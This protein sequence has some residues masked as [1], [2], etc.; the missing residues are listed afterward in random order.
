VQD[1]G[2]SLTFNAPPRR[3]VTYYHLALEMMIALGL[4]S[5]VVGR[6][7]FSESPRLPQQEAAFRSIP[8]IVPGPYPPAREQ[9]LAKA[10]DFVFVADPV[11]ELDRDRGYADRA[12]LEAGGATVYVTAA[13]CNDDRPATV[14]DVYTDLTNL[15]RIFG[16][17]GR[18]EALIKQIQTRIEATSAKVSGRTPKR[19]MVYSAGTGPL[20]VLTGRYF[21]LPKFAGGRNVFA[22]EP[23]TDAE[24]SR[25]QVVQANPEV[26]VV[27]NYQP[28]PSAEQKRDFLFKTFPTTDAAKN[29]SWVT[30]DNIEAAPGIRN[31]DTVEVL[32][33]AL[34]PEAF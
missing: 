24:V 17:A 25:E 3:V 21:E 23:G 29:R 22:D 18:A 2:R 14:R 32:A 15:G 9:V 8:E 7:G 28:G 5:K 31:A 11:Y 27:D 33:R 16:V 30:I 1:C 26:F 19:I 34:H 12:Q 6:E 10:P 13:R 20:S 4:Q